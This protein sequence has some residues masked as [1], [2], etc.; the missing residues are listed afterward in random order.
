MLLLLKKKG[1]NGGGIGEKQLAAATATLRF[2]SRPFVGV[3]DMHS[4]RG[5]QKG[6]VNRT[7]YRKNRSFLKFKEPFLPLL[8]PLELTV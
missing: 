4:N 2:Q 6:A 3:E 7:I 5:I 8:L 1:D